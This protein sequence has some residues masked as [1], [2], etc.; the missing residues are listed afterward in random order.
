[1]VFLK[2]MERFISNGLKNNKQKLNFINI[3]KRG[4]TYI[5]KQVI[6]KNT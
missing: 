4:H 2:D 1:M 6:I 5:S 3:C